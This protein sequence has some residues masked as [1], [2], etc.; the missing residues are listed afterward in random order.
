[1]NPNKLTRELRKLPGNIRSPKLPGGTLISAVLDR[2]LMTWSDR[3]GAS[4]IFGEI[5]SEHCWVHLNNG[6]TIFESESVDLEQAEI[7]RLDD[8]PKIALQ[9]GRNQLPNPD[10]LVIYRAAASDAYS[11]RA[12]DAKFA[13]DR[14]RRIQVSPEAIRDLIELPGSHARA[15]IETRIGPGA[16]DRLHYESGAFLGPNSLLNDYFFER[17][18]T[19]SDPAIPAQ[20]IH[21]IAVGAEK[22]FSPTEEYRL[23]ELFHSIDSISADEPKSELVVGM[24]Y[25]R[26]ATAARW[27][28]NQSQ[29]PLLSAA[30]PEPVA[31]D[32]VFDETHR[33]ISAGE[34]AYGLIE[35]WSLTAEKQIERQKTVQDAARVP[36]RMSEIRRL[37]EQRGLGDE[38]KLVRRLRGLL[39]VAFRPLLIERTGEIPPTPNQSLQQTVEFVSGAS[40]SLRPEMQQLAIELADQ[41]AAEESLSNEAVEKLSN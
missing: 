40:R 22:L 36:V 27:F 10:F 20:E 26:L 1:M 5:W 6:A 16:I 3:G 13:V 8:M 39:E 7:I 11:V 31:V 35:S 4:R 24:Y 2:R 21:L 28:A 12:I 9:A 19:G 38:K 23:M 14:L 32:E 17:H 15:A 18:T 25:L 33:R 41:L 37:L 29:L 30:E 34:S